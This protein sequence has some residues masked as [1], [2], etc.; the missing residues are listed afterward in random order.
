MASDHVGEAEES[1]GS[2]GKMANDQAVRLAAVL[3]DEDKVRNFVLAARV[4]Q[5][6]CCVISSIDSLGIRE[7]EA[8]FLYE[9]DEA[10][11]G[12]T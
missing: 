3:M 4:N 7:N 5:F 2:V 6:L 9:L 8:H 10:G 12:I 11:A 1:G